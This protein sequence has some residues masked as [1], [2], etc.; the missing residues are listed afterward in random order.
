MAEVWRVSVHPR[1]SDQDLNGHVNHVSIL[2]LLEEA[3]VKW[4]ATGPV[5]EGRGERPPTVVA[6]LQVDYRAPVNYGPS[7]EIEMRV[8][9]VGN[10][11]FALGYRAYQEDTVVLEASTVLVAV[12]HGNGASR[13]LEERERAWLASYAGA[14]VSLG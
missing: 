13:P 7:V 2:S 4:R 12:D 1:W 8:I 5:P 6:S 10:S 9:R 3:R 14:E 11:S